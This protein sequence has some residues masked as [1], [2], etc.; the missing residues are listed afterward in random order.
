MRVGNIKRLS[1][2]AD[3]SFL[4]IRKVLEAA[5]E[6]F[7][8]ILDPALS[9]K[10]LPLFGGGAVSKIRAN[11]LSEKADD[12]AIQKC[13]EPPNAKIRPKEVLLKQL[14]IFIDSFPFSFSFLCWGKA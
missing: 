10:N 8:K 4:C 2:P 14:S 13:A 11:S 12:K 5:G 6:S 9:G 1:R 3:K 7:L